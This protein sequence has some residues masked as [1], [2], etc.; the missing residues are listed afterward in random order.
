MPQPRGP[1]QSRTAA[2]CPAV[3]L[4]RSVSLQVWRYGTRPASDTA[5]LYEA[6]L[7]VDAT[8][9]GTCATPEDAAVLLALLNGGLGHWLQANWAG[10]LLLS[11]Q[12]APALAFAQDHPGELGRPPAQFEHGPDEHALACYLLGE[13]CPVLFAAHGLQVR[14]LVLALDPGRA[15]RVVLRA[16]HVGSASCRAEEAAAVTVWTRLCDKTK[17][18]LVRRSDR[19]T[20]G[21]A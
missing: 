13:V 20:S 19:D 10:R 3:K 21:D 17:F 7:R 12:D 2:R 4:T 9:Y 6:G 11:A 1:A 18:G 15:A 14:E 5:E 8:A 16:G